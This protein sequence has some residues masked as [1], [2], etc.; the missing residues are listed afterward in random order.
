MKKHTDRLV[1][2]IFALSVVILIITFSIGLPIYVRPF[3]YA[4]I[5]ALEMTEYTGFDREEIKEAYDE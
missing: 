5:D 4:H 3:Y 2:F 1:S